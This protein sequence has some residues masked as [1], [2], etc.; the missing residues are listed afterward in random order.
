[1]IFSLTIATQRTLGNI[2]RLFKY[3]LGKQKRGRERDTKTAS[4][5]IV[6]MLYGAHRIDNKS[7]MKKF[8]TNFIYSRLPNGH[9]ESSVIKKL[10]WQ[11]VAD[12]KKINLSWPHV[13]G[14][15]SWAN[16]IG[17]HFNAR[18]IVCLIQFARQILI[19]IA[20]G[21]SSALWFDIVHGHQSTE[22]ANLF[23]FFAVD[24][25]RRLN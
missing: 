15:K 23:S 12:R 18:N 7:F 24:F 25:V 13:N 5:R 2:C 22:S 1:M 17:E 11:F 14:E 6:C 20:A 3:L 19:H 21:A 9:N 16:L 4:T 10:R 8:P